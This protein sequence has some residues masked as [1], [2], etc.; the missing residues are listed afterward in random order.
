M[1]PRTLEEFELE[2]EK[3]ELNP[4]WDTLSPTEYYKTVKDWDWDEVSGHKP[5]AAIH[6]E[7][8][9]SSS[10]YEM[11]LKKAEEEGDNDGDLKDEVVRA[12]LG[13]RFSPKNPIL[14]E[15][16]K[17]VPRKEYSHVRWPGLPRTVQFTLGESVSYW[18]G[19]P[20]NEVRKGRVS[21]IVQMT[22]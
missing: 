7:D 8:W 9:G 3:H 20:W 11:E 21:L 14:A 22:V 5:T 19:P 12:A 13:L 15:I 4:K 2:R 1:L 17:E 16:K 10:N 6:E 18:S